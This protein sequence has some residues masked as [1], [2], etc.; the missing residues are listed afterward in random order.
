[1]FESTQ[2]TKRNLIFLAIAVVIAILIKVFVPINNG[3][4]AKGASYLGIFVATIFLWISCDTSWPSLLALVSLGV[5]RIIDSSDLFTT[6]FGNYV[7][8][9][10]IAAMM[11]ST[12]LEET[13]AA[14]YIAKWFLSRKAIK[15]HLIIFFVCLILATYTISILVSCMLAILVL[16]PIL[17]ALMIN[18]GVSKDEK[19]YKASVLLIFWLSTSAELMFPFGKVIPV[20]IM[21][22]VETYGYSIDISKYCAFTIPANI[23]YIVSG[24]FSVYLFLNPRNKRFDNYDVEAIRNDLLMNP[25]SKRAKFAIGMTIFCFI[26]LLMPSL[27]FLGAVSSY[28][29]SYETVLAYYIP[30]I[31]MCIIPIDGKPLIDLR[32]D[33]AKVPWTLVLF[34]GVVMLFTS[35]TA[36]ADFGLT[37]W[38]TAIM[39]PVTYI[40]SPR[41]LLV[42][43][44]VVTAVITNFI[45]NMVTMTIS[46]TVFAP[47][48]VNLYNNGFTDIHPATVIIMLGLAASMSCLTPSS[49]PTAPIVY[50]GN[51]KVKDVSLA[52]TG[53]IIFSILV[54][55]AIGQLVGNIW[56]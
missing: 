12:Q 45:S 9:L 32:R 38:I 17:N 3:L 41:A 50:G 34:L 27:S 4:T 25:L 31:L 23:G 15:G 13:G 24:I 54:V 44:V 7:S 11:L 30:I 48:F 20:M 40:L 6:T 28:F 36:S 52:N 8:S 42:F 55:S 37:A 18:I 53:F 22:F 21:N 51:I 33:S 43:A 56:L 29:A 35:Y 49:T 10:V 16:M 39:T 14:Q 2:K 26:L 1:M 46:I 5:F 19:L 47:V